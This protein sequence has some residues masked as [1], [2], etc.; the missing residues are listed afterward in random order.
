M[1]NIIA[2]PLL[3][4]EHWWGGLNVDGH[5]MPYTAGFSRSLHNMNGNMGAPLL[6]SNKGRFVWS[7]SPFAFE[8]TDDALH[9]REVDAEDAPAFQAPEVSAGHNNLRGAY[10]AA[11]RAHFPS[12]GA[13][14]DPLFFTAPQYNLWIELLYSPNQRDVLAYAGRLLELGFPPGVLMIDTMWTE[15]YGT[16][17]FHSGRFPDPK[18]MVQ[19]LNAMGFPVMLWLV[20]FVSP[21]SLTYRQLRRKG[22][23]VRDA[24]GEPAIGTWWDGRSAMIDLLNAD[25]LAW[26]HGEM[27]MLTTEFGIAGFKLDS[28]QPDEFRTFGVKDPFAYTDAWGRVGLRYRMAE[29]KDTWKMGGQPLVQR[30]RDRDHSWDSSRGFGS[31]ISF[32]I[33]EGLLGY[34]YTCPDMIGGGE[35]TSFPPY[36]RDVFD[37]ELFVRSAQCSA[38]M[39]MM[40]FSAAPWR[41]LEGEHLRYCIEAAQLHARMGQ[42]ILALAQ[43]SSTSCEPIMRHVAYQFPEGDYATINDQFMLGDRILVAPAV[44]KGAATRKVVFPEGEW[45]G[46]AGERIVGPATVEIVTPL[47]RLPW[48]RKQ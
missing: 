8:F 33:A 42:E 17:R 1:N 26:L 2:I 7:E 45:E 3:P 27:D 19:R 30:T 9:I 35:Y 47:S 48:F 4:D 15:D 25:A 36:G 10:L 14:P 21:D 39:P 44:V 11:A 46:D 16:L 31:L 5:R 20:P 13:M 40:Q 24:H 32:G 18:A 6:V 41:M 29:Y 38:L 43:H 22:L 34:A 28:G 12:T 37:P 23:L